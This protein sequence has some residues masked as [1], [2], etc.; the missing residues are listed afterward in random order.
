MSNTAD[1]T[2]CTDY[3]PV[4]EQEGNLSEKKFSMSRLNREAIPTLD[5]SWNDDF[6]EG[7]EDDIVAVFDFDYAQMI[8]FRTK[9][10]AVN[11]ACVA[12]MCVGYGTAAAF[13]FG[14]VFALGVYAL[15]LAPCM[16]QR[17]IR[18]DAEAQHICV[19]RDGIRY[20]TDRHKTC[21]GMAM[22]EVGKRSKTVPFD[23]ITD[24]DIRE[25]VGATSCCITNV[26]FTVYMHV[27]TASSGGEAKKI[28]LQ[29][30]GL[31]EPHKFKQLVWAMKRASLGSAANGS[32]YQAPGALEMTQRGGGGGDPKVVE[33]L[34]EDIRE[35]LRA[36]NQLLK[37]IN[38]QQ[39]PVG[40]IVD[41]K[42]AATTSITDVAKKAAES[43]AC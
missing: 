20:V 33:G 29:I 13:P 30:V 2:T 34:L 31:K 28:E 10:A 38:Q 18:W 9:V 41:K 39:Q 1:A 17:Q 14:G 19:T 5:L 23:K 27:D 24:C 40:T 12:A 11:Q 32:L 37:D 16:F 3:K 42:Q 26:L 21:W 8:D 7:E 36:N 22:C 43:T 25:P 35:E 4:P 15:S 6:F